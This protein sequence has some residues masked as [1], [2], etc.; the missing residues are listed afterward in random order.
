[1]PAP[2]D[3]LGALSVVLAIV[4]FVVYFWQTLAGEVRPHP[5]SWVLFGILSVTGYLVQRDAGAR[6]GSWALLAMSAIC[7]LLAATSVFRGERRFPLSE[8]AF[9]AAGAIVFAFYLVAREA[10]VAALAIT[11]VDALGFGPT[12]ARAWRA[13]HRD[14]ATAFTLNGAKF[15]PSLMAMDP[16]TFATAFY[17]A[18]LVALNLA[19]A[20][21]LLGRRRSLG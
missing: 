20:A 6:A 7:F 13:P 11:L 18:T 19:V 21:V 15:L 9:L 5:L 3:A 4:A 1:M 12:F 8:W 14:S 10:N 16:F 17:P 2:Q